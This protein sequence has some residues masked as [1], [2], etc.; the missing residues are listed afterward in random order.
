MK[1]KRNRT[2]FRQSVY[3]YVLIA[4]GLLLVGII[5]IYPLLRGIVSS[6]SHRLPAAWNSKN[7]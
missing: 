1:A 6:F 7:L 5:L 4:P 3:A 2:K